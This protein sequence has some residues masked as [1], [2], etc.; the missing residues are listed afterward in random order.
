MIVCIG[1]ATRDM[2]YDV[3]RHPGADDLVVATER[4]VAGGGPAATAAV[5]MARLGAEVRFVGVLDGDLD[6]IT[7]VVRVPGRMVESTIL[8]NENGRS[9]ITEAA[10][11]FSVGAGVL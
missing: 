8:V 6:G 5:A 3:P 9:I 1:L 2:I 7:D 4:T 11:Q 10:P